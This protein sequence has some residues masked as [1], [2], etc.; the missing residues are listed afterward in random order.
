M[1]TRRCTVC[2]NSVEL[3]Q[4]IA[5]PNEFVSCSRCGARASLRIKKRNGRVGGLKG[6]FIPLWI[7]RW[8]E[9]RR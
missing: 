1:A 2:G 4:I 5:G 6:G 3:P 9:I 7:W 8:N